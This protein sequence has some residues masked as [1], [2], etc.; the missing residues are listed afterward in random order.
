MNPKTVCAIIG[1]SSVLQDYYRLIEGM[2]GV[3]C[4]YIVTQ[5]NTGVGNSYKPYCRIVRDLEPVLADEAV[6]FAIIINEPTKH[7]GVANQLLR[8]GKRVLIEKPIALG[9][10]LFER[11]EFLTLC[12]AAQ[13]N[14]YVVAQHRFSPDFIKLR[15]LLDQSRPSVGYLSVSMPRDLDYYRAGNGW[16]AKYSSVWVNQAY[17]WLDILVWYFGIPT[18]VLPAL[19]SRREGLNVIDSCS[20]FLK[21]SCGLVIHVYATT[22]FRNA[23]FDLRFDTRSGVL[24][25][26]DVQHSLMLPRIFDAV[27]CRRNSTWNLKRQVLC[28][29]LS[30]GVVGSESLVMPEEAFLVR[31]LALKLSGEF[32][33][34]LQ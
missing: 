25:H 3:S 8:V 14:A 1:A 20:G 18:A 34:D 2:Q 16:R 9:E 12:K 19:S 29:F 26:R 22:R 13:T 4:K 32:V 23:W 28:G 27:F 6:G 24:T 15:K 30:A 11:N 5:T 31:D 21:F 7:L 33:E 17:H 10:R